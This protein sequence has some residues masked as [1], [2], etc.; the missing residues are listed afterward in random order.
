MDSEASMFDHIELML[1]DETVEPSDM[2]LSFLTAI[3]NNF[4]EDQTIGR[5]GFA[6]V[7]KV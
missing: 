7:Y 2:P 3:T 5:G 6:V 1:L 4:S